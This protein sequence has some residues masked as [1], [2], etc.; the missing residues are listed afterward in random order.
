MRS[1]G[2]KSTVLKSVK[3]NVFSRFY[4]RINIII[5]YYTVGCLPSSTDS[6]AVA[7]TAEITST[8]NKW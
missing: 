1:S 6:L 7:R 2:E 5:K 4:T 8:N 3:H